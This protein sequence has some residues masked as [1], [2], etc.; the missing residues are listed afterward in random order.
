[1]NKLKPDISILTNIIPDHL[2]WHGSMKK[3]I[4]AKEKIFLN[5][6]NNDLAIINVDNLE[7][8]IR[9]LIKEKLNLL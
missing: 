3:Y 9:K 7:G 1:M 5:Q 8:F 4:S 2:E 6:N